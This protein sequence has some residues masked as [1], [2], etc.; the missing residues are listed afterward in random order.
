MGRRIAL[1]ATE[2]F[3]LSVLEEAYRASTSRNF[4]H[5][6]G[7]LPTYELALDQGQAMALQ[8]DPRD[9]G[10]ARL[11]QQLRLFGPDG[12]MVLGLGWT[13]A[14]ISTPTDR[15]L[16]VPA[17]I[18]PYQVQ[19]VTRDGVRDYEL[20][21]EPASYSPGPQALGLQV[22]SHPKVGAISRPMDMALL[23]RQI[24]RT[25]LDVIELEDARL[26]SFVSS[27]AKDWTLLSA[28]AG[29]IGSDPQ[30]MKSAAQV[31]SKKIMQM[32]GLEK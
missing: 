22:T 29:P 31:V 19:K 7:S 9:D 27:Y 17:E 1:L 16:V 20:A 28:I 21:A 8:V 4:K 14:G 5:N 24:A 13:Q 15:R 23:K 12:I 32:L 6:S 2:K 30:G 18:H 3:P 26:F 11:D 10:Y 25:D